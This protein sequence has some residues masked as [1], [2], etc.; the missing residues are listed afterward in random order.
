[1]EDRDDPAHCLRRFPDY[2]PGPERWGT[3]RSPNRPAD[4]LTSGIC[5]P[6]V[7]SLALSAIVKAARRNGATERRSA[8]EFLRATLD[9]WLAWHDWLATV[10][11][12][13][14]TGLLEIHHS[15]ESGMDNSPRWDAPYSRVVP[16]TMDPFVRR[17]TAH[18]QDANERPTDTDYRR[19]LWLVDQMADACYDDAAVARTV[20]FRVSDVFS[21]ALL[22]LA[23][24]V[25]AELA[26]SVG[27]RSAGTH[28]RD[29]AQRF[30]DGVTAAVSPETGLARDRDLRTGEWLSTAT[31]GGF[32]P[33]LCGGAPGVVAAQRAQ[34]MGPEWCGHP[35]LRYAVPPSTSPADASFRP[36]RYW[37]GPQWPVISWLFARAAAERGD[38]ELAEALREESL[39]Q[40]SD[41]SFAEYYHPFT[42]EPLGSRH[43]SWTAAVALDWSM[44]R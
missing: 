43:Q 15:W 7:H 9:R 11:D 25:L 16:G 5:Q 41:A 8:E 40:L 31:I 22:A 23:S 18:V 28:L 27:R 20:D 10:R 33:L 14:R 44:V 26:E 39:R 29:I 35:E 24:D 2:F 34:F 30:R 6:P 13:D 12:P 3:G 32:A 42:G 1:M 19:Y 37:R 36:R 17:D 21:S 4:L 38:V